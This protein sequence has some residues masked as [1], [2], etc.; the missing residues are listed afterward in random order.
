MCFILILL[1][2][3][4]NDTWDITYSRGLNAFNNYVHI[5]CIYKTTSYLQ[6][7][8]PL[9]GKLEYPHESNR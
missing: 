5:P 1:A 7:R 9:F 8:S 6:E 3:N 2:Y 4:G